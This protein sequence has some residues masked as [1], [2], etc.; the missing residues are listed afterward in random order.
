LYLTEL[1][2]EEYLVK[3]FATD[4]LTQSKKYILLSGITMGYLVLTKIIFGYVLLFAFTV[5]V[6]LWL[7]N[8]PAVNYRKNLIILLIAFTTIMP[9]LIYTFY[10]TGKFFYLGSSGADSLYWMSSPYDG[11]YGDWQPYPETPQPFKYRVYYSEDSIAAHHKKD[12]DE[13]YK[14]HGT[15]RERAYTEIAINNIK[16]HPVK[17][18]KNCLSNIGRMLFSYPNAYTLQNNKTL[19]RLPLNGLISI[20]SLFCIIPTFLNWRKIN[21]PIRFLLFCV[22]IYLGPSTMVSG[23]TRMFTVIAPILLV[24]IAFIMQRTLK[25][26][27][28]FNEKNS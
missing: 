1:N 11:E 19:L 21:F 16:S 28:R 24:W 4:N 2:P 10:L 8:R 3:A 20:L 27:F 23:L 26:S 12:I 5:N 6:F 22:L 14:L 25:I 18:L 9:Y 17:F 15:E 7:L 13:I